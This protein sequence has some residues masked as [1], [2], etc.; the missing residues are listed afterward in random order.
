MLEISLRDRLVGLRPLGAL[1]CA[2][3]ALVKKPSM[4]YPK[5][6]KWQALAEFH[7]LRLTIHGYPLQSSIRNTK[8][9]GLN[10]MEP[11]MSYSTNF[12]ALKIF[13]PLLKRQIL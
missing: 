9:G 6:N 2:L 1:F 5:K 10:L 7:F 13:P 12:Q 11:E 4:R 3:E 8:G